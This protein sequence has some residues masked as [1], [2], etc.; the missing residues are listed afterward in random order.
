MKQEHDVMGKLVNL[1][2]YQSEADFDNV[3]FES[4]AE[5][6]PEVHNIEALT[7]EIDKMLTTLANDQ[8]IPQA[9]AMA[10][11][12]YAAFSL[13][14]KHGRAEALAFF[15]DCIQTAEICEDILKEI[16]PPSI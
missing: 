12:R 14:Q 5:L 7:I 2:K 16:E 9:V 11:G 13:F 15:E 1:R 3:D 10:A 6:Y 4:M 8:P